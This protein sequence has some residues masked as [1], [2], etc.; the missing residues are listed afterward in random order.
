MKGMRAAL[1]GLA[2]ATVAAA[3]EPRWQPTA[4]RAS[5]PVRLGRPVPLT[6]ADLAGPRPE[7][8]RLDPGVVRVSYMLPPE[9]V[10]PE[11]PDPQTDLP[12][13][14]SA[15][16]PL[17][18]AVPAT[19]PWR[20]NPALP[21]YTLP[22]RGT[23]VPANPMPPEPPPRETERIVPMPSPA[24]AAAR[25]P[26]GPVEAAPSPRP[27]DGPAPMPVETYPGSD[28]D[29]YYTSYVETI[30][31]GALTQWRVDAEFL[32]WW[33]Q[34]GTLAAPLLPVRPSP[35]MPRRACG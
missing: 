34:K 27:L 5:L 26:E 22:S 19:S 18:E 28:Q 30:G 24:P 12:L 8:P 29:E 14:P 20:P 11:P 32:T 15:P 33:L 4:P 3:E 1:V 25:K 10:I 13:L 17:I 31:P 7:P 6:A 9:P 23:T 2:L 35:T 16:T 21:I